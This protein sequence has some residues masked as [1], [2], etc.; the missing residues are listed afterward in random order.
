M[1]AEAA[2][3]TTNRSDVIAAIR[4]ASAATGSD[5][6]YLL[7]TAMRESSL[8][9]Q[10]KSET[11]SACGLYQFVGQTWLGMIKQYGAKYGLASDAAAITQDSD[12]RYRV[13]NAGDR[14]AIL[15]LRND[16]RIAALMEG[17]YANQSRAALENTL[18]RNVRSGELYA[19]HFLGP[20]AACKLIRMSSATPD[21]CAASAFPAAADANRGVFYH[22]DGSAKTVREVYNWAMKQPSGA[23]ALATSS[24]RGQGKAYIDN[25]SSSTDWL[26]GQMYEA[27]EPSNGSLGLLP[28]TPVSLTPGVIH[29]LSS[30]TGPDTDSRKN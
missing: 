6:N 8:K 15:A 10:A 1:L 19:A 18:G 30:L 29:I 21:A 11:S 16:P 27:T 24:A 2:N 12:G 26:A 14:Q 28:L 4:Q 20:G 22:A 17:E 3:A 9:P 13:G 5:F 25:T 7:D 23:G